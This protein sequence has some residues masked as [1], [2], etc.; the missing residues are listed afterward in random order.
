M[1]GRNAEPAIDILAGEGWRERGVRLYDRAYQKDDPTGAEKWDTMRDLGKVWATEAELH[2][3]TF[4]DANTVMLDDTMRKM[5]EH[6]HN[7]LLVP[8]MTAGTLM[9]EAVDGAV[10]VNVRQ[11]IDQL[12]FVFGCFSHGLGKRVPCLANVCRAWQTC[13]VLDVPCLKSVCHGCCGPC[14]CSC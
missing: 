8:T 13:A 7:V 11:Y 9:T 6:P 3:L 4:S 14:A 2:H 5:R 12:L 1:Q 10:L